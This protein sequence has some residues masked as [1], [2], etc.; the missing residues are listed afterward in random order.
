L[1]NDRDCWARKICAERNIVQ[2][3]LIPIMKS[4]GSSDKLFDIALRLTVNLCQPIFVLF[5]GSLF[6][7]P[8][9]WVISKEI[10][11]NLIK[12]KPAFVDVAF[13]K[14]LEKKMKE[15]FK[16]EWTARDEES[17]LVVE[18]ILVLLRYVL[19]IGENEFGLQNTHNDAKLHDQLLLAI[20]ESKL[21]DLFIDLASISE[22]RDF[23]LLLM[24]IVALMIKH[25]EPRNIIN[26]QRNSNCRETNKNQDTLNTKSN[27]EKQPENRKYL[28]PSHSGFAGSFVIK[29]LKA[30]NKEKDIVVHRI[31]PSVN[32]LDHLNHRKIQKRIPKNRRPFELNEEQYHST[33]KVRIFLKNFCENFLKRSYNRLMNSCLDS[34]FAFRR[35]FGQRYTDIHYYI[36][37]SYIMEFRRLLNLPS[38]L[39]KSTNGREGFHRVQVKID[40]YLEQT[41]T[42][43]KEA[44]VHGLRASF[45]IKAYKELL[46]T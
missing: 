17:R 36:L 42:D 31:L 25:H 5:A 22:E 18:R 38:S 33:L 13:L 14:I 27:V 10:E 8:H 43:R 39:V 12:S 2:C 9:S 40:N 16:M 37:M 46:C 45:A 30:L 23:H 3:D 24:E 20:A 11:A 35:N 34:A 19:M 21:D 6:D 1:R 15:F 44:R 41:I 7:N 4:D 28:S 26:S 29:G 32:R